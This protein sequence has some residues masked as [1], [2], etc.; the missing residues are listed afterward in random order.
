MVG[1]EFALLGAGA[2][3]L[4][5][6]GQYRWVAVWVCFGVGALPRRPAGASADRLG[7]CPLGHSLCRHRE[8]AKHDPRPAGVRTAAP[9]ARPASVNTAPR[10]VRPPPDPSRHRR[11]T[12]RA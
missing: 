12:R 10:W 8:P 1:L 9:F 11:G 3:V 6:T 7:P 2:A 4:G 5:V